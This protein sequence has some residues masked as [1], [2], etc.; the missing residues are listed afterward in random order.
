MTPADLYR[1]CALSAWRLEVLQDYAVPGDEERQRAFHAGEPLPSP[2]PGKRDN[3]ALVARLTE[4]GRTVGRI[5][6]VDRPLSDYVRYELAVYAENAA[7]GEEIRIADRS[8]YPELGEITGDF[9]IFDAERSK[10]AVILFGYD[11]SGLVAATRSPTTARPWSG[12]GIGLTWHTP[13]QF[14]LPSSQRLRLPDEHIRHRAAR[15]RARGKAGLAAGSPRH[16]RP[17]ARPPRLR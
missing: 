4:A 12:A 11:E 15:A 13:T 9:A 6:V 3:L 14:P 2:R 17:R 8:L 1:D 5:H 16:F 7:A 10:A